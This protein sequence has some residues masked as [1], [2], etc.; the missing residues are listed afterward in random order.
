LR[1]AAAL[2]RL[3]R[4]VFPFTIRGLV[5]FLLAAGLLCLGIMRA[6]LAGLFWGSSFMLFTLYALGAGHLFRFAVHRRKTA[7]SARF[8]LPAAGVF[9]GEEIEAVVTLRLPRFLPPGFSAH[10]SLPLSC[11]ERRIKDISLRVTPGA[12]QAR[13]GF[14]AV[15]R[16]VYE[17]GSAILEAH[18]VLGLTAHCISFPRQERLTVFPSLLPARELPGL[19]EQKDGAVA[20]SPRR[21]RSEEL[22]EARKYYPGDDVRRLNW[23]VFAHMDELFLRIGEEVPPPEPQIL[24]ILDTTANPLVP[25]AVS[26]DYLDRLVQSCASLMEHL[27]ARGRDV[28]FSTPGERECST[29]GETSRGPMLAAL[30]GANWTTARWAP[31][32]PG[33]GLHAVVFSSPGSPGLS[34]I[35]STVQTRG[36]SVGLFLQDMEPGGR[37]P[38]PRVRDFLLLPAEPQRKAAGPRKRERSRFSDALSRDLA[39]YRGA[40][41]RVGHAAEI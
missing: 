28:T 30:A 24:F 41:R 7:D 26:S 6:D 27:A 33:G 22:L 39:L 23:K 19:A 15:H 17:G 36:W 40:A 29:W 5:I 8:S 20:E 9:P 32:L 1:P 14:T 35:M 2:S 12:S 18:D 31:E 13:L 4:A 21:R 38:R 3:V 11:N 34:R 10:L 16:G 37:A 25:P